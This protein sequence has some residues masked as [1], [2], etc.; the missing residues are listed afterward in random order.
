MFRNPKKP[1]ETANRQSATEAGGRPDNIRHLL[2][3]PHRTTL[4]LTPSCPRLGIAGRCPGLRDDP[5]GSLPILA[6]P[7]ASSAEVVCSSCCS[8]GAPLVALSPDGDRQD[9]GHVS[10]LVRVK[11]F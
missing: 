5:I 7:T 3:N 9:Y 8:K 4:T 6:S 11:S 2:D 10:A 1:G